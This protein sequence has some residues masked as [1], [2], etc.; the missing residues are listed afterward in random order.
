MIQKPIAG[1]FKTIPTK[2]IRDSKTRKMV[3][4]GLKGVFAESIALS[5]I[6]DQPSYSIVF[7]GAT[8]INFEDTNNPTY[9]DAIYHG[10]GKIGQSNVK[11][12]SYDTDRTKYLNNLILVDIPSVQ[13]GGQRKKISRRL[14]KL[15]H[16][17]NK[18]KIQ[19]QKSKKN[20]K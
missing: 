3:Q 8:P 18:N 6:Q 12:F 5:A 19:K 9:Q 16:K 15:T 1:S 20:R 2:E 10:T 14:K 11:V 13:S 7:D 17:K 4:V